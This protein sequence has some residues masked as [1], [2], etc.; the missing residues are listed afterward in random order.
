MSLQMI[1]AQELA[2]KVINDEHLF[3]LDV[4]S[5]DDFDDWRIEGSHVEII[6]APYFELTEGIE[7]I[8]NS[9]PDHEEVYTICAKGNASKMVAEQFI[10]DGFTNIYSVEGGMRAWSQHLEPVKIADLTGGGELYQFVRI[11]KGCLSYMMVS[12]GE[13]IVVDPARTLHVYE[14]FAAD[15]GWT[16]KHVIDTH[17]HADHISGGRTLAQQTGAAYWMPPQDAESAN[18]SYESLTEKSSVAF[19]DGSVDVE[20][21]HSPGHTEGSTSL[22]VDQAYLFTGDILFVASIGR[23]DLAGK[24]GDWANQLR[25]TLYHRYHELSKQ[26]IVL[27]AHFGK[28]SE[29]NKDGSVQAELGQLYQENAGL[30]IEDQ[31]EF[32]KQVSE[33]LPPQPNSYEDIRQT[34]M[35]KQKPSEDEQSEMEVGPNRCA[36]HE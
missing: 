18:F 13:A 7:S 1:T 25:D 21:L 2:Q 28:M 9:I 23:P 14:N 15:H 5:K 16:I 17:L 30:Q 32:K 8:R 35:G 26:M 19:G 29:M 10:E 36:V 3:I 6:N 12:S 22:I 20:A 34:N 31:A 33:N 27:P 11:G 24:A 4:R